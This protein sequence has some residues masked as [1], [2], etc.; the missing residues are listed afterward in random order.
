MQPPITT[1]IGTIAGTPVIALPGAPD[2]ALGAWWTLALP[3]LDRLSARQPR[4]ALK[5]P[6]ARKLASGIGVAE[7]ALLQKF[8][9]TWMPLA[10][11]DLS[12]DAMLRADGWFAISADSEG[13]AA[14]T[15]VDAY[16]LRDQP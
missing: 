8:D 15:P 7:I 1:A 2:P 13:F 10:S 12:L 6:L 9:G 16:L 4:P 14:G 5:L 11:G 3:V